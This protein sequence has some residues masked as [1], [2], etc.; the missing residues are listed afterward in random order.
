M[1]LAARKIYTHRIILTVPERERS[2]QYGSDL[3]AVRA[4]LEGVTPE[5]IIEE[6]LASVETPL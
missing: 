2:L 1:D 3:E 5:S 4:Y 6:V